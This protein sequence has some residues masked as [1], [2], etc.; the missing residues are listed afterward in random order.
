[1]SSN[2]SMFDQNTS[3]LLPRVDICPSKWQI[4]PNVT[5]YFKSMHGDWDRSRRIPFKEW[6]SLGTTAVE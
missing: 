4:K 6:H 3:T 2:P 1:M 5:A